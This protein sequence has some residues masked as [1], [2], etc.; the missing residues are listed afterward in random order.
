MSS[1]NKK[2][3]ASQVVKKLEAKLKRKRDDEYGS[4]SEDEPVQ[5]KQTPSKKRQAIVVKAPPKLK[6]IG[7][8][9]DSDSESDDEDEEDMIPLEKP[10]RRKRK[11][12]RQKAAEAQA[13]EEQSP[14][15]YLGHIPYGFFEDQMRSFFAQFGDIQN[16]R[17]SR[18]KKTGKSKHFAFIEFETTEVAQI[19][20]QTMDGYLL[21][22]HKLVCHT[23]PKKEIHP[24]IFKN[25]NKKF[26]KIPWKKIDRLQHNKEKEPEQAAKTAERL[27]Q[28][29]KRTR[30]KI[31]ALGIDYDFPGYAGQ[32]VT[33]S[34]RT[35]FDAE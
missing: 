11:A 28:K 21:F 3:K 2:S 20:A 26:V 33:R 29:E 32:R 10:S 6:D 31:A 16:L 17:L 14:I 22:G 25:A 18:N 12:A 19:V 24:G 15:V 9:V 7:P 13:V 4:D 35:T 23:V 34:K 5:K 30:S 1:R 27:V 8:E